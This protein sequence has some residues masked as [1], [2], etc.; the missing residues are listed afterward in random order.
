MGILLRTHPLLLL[1]HLAQ[2]SLI[3]PEPF[4]LHAKN[5]LTSSLWTCCLVRCCEF[6]YIRLR[7]KMRTSACCS[8]EVC[9]VFTKLL[10]PRVLEIY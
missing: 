4:I 7:I 1:F 5:H 6:H 10:P 2:L 9:M 3:L 8:H